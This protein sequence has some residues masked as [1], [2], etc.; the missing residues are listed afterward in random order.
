MVIRTVAC[1]GEDD[2]EQATPP[3]GRFASVSAQGGLL[4]DYASNQYEAGH[5]CGVMVD[6][7][8]ACWG[9]NEDG[10]ASPPPGREEESPSHLDLKSMVDKR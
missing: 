10:Q 2:A 3:D 1:W 6:G 5:T 8:V 7:S 9:H 4:G